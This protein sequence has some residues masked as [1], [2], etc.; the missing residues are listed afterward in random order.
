MNS[1]SPALP[2]IPVCEPTLGPR[3]EACVMDAIRSG[4]ISSAGHYLKQFEQDFARFIGVPY[5]VATTNGTTALHLALVAA[6]VGPGDEVIVPDF[7]MIAC[8][9]AVVYC[10]AKPVFVDADPETW[11]IDPSRINAAVTPRTKA[12]MPVHIYGH[13]AD[14]DPILTIAKRHGL[15]VVEDAAEAHGALYKGRICG[16][17]GTLGAFS[18][19]AN[20]IVTTGEGGMVVTSDKALWERCLRFK[21]LCFS[22]GGGRS[23]WHDDIGFNYR[24]TNLQAAVGVAQLERVDTLIEARRSMAARYRQA[25]QGIPHLQLPV[26]RDWAKNVY[27][28][29]GIALRES[30]P[31]SA[32]EVMAALKREGIDTRAFFQPL[33]RQPGLE[34]AGLAQRG[35]F[36][37]SEYL[38]RR[39]FYL[40]SS[41]HLT[42]AQIDRVAGTL[43]RLLG[44]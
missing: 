23:Y 34:K 33:H 17:L 15:A 21:N 27:W 28:M 9:Y 43:R 12:I 13:P 18:F 3:E 16:S 20:K 10:G 30:C 39:G 22:L 29:F 36:P 19:Y 1:D 32:E 6:G 25:L 4:W 8:A 42:P 7:T 37:V 5:A 24:M 41:G 14:M 40:P 2:F 11:T 44:A 35:D 38:A 26:E 31:M